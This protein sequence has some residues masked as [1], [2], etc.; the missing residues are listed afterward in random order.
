[1]NRHGIY[2]EGT[3]IACAGLVIGMALTIIAIA[4]GA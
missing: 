2:T 4:G 1:M 3:L